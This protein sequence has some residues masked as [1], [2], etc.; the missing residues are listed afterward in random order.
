MFRKFLVVLLIVCSA[1]VASAA[2]ASANEAFDKHVLLYGYCDALAQ[3]LGLRADSSGALSVS[4]LATPSADIPTAGVYRFLSAGKSYVASVSTSTPLVLTS[5]AT[6]STYPAQIIVNSSSDLWWSTSS[7]AT[8]A[9]IW[10]CNK[11]TANTSL[12]WSIKSSGGLIPTFIASSTGT[13]AD[14]SAG[15]VPYEH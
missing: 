10:K 9:W 7:T 13:V 3:W 5:F 2:P 15:V 4:I 14:I 1:S 8:A 12:I 6:I 11:L